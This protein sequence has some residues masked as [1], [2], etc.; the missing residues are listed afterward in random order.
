MGK[1]DWQSGSFKKTGSSPSSPGTAIAKGGFNA[2]P[3]FAQFH[4]STVQAFADGGAVYVPRGEAE[5]LDTSA[6]APAAPAA[7]DDSMDIKAVDASP[8][9]DASPGG[10]DSSSSSSSDDYSDYGPSTGRGAAGTSETTTAP[11]A[12]A[13]APAPRK[14]AIDIGESVGGG[15]GRVNPPAAQPSSSDSSPKLKAPAAK[16]FDPGSGPDPL[17]MLTAGR[18]APAP[19][20]R[21]TTADDEDSPAVAGIKSVAGSVAGAVKRGFNA[22]KSSADEADKMRVTQRA[23]VR[24]S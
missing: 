1:P 20:S 9:A 3:G 19:V 24:K 4:G 22:F 18:S 6:S 15:R 2:P 21:N 5:Y 17:P 7:R 12:P 14:R 16:A 13:P 11:P 8:V 23:N 10:S